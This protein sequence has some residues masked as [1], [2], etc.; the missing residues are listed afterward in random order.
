MSNNFEKLKVWKKAHELVLEVYKHTNIFPSFEKYGLVSQIRRSS[1]SI[2]TNIVEGYKRKTHK[3]FERFL[4][5]AES[6]LE[7][8]KYLLLLSRDLKYLK[9]NDYILLIEL[10]DEV[11]KML[12]GFQKRL[13][14]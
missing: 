8:T 1:S 10:A 11:G 3:D 5:I 2:A 6:S 7:E 13:K 12:H 14:T 4:N 9:N